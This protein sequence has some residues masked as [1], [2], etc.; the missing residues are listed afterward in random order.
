MFQINGKVSFILYLNDFSLFSFTSG[1]IILFLK[2]YL[3]VKLSKV[4]KAN[5]IIFKVV[6]MDKKF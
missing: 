6:R 5:K 4:P 1:K 2:M 3:L